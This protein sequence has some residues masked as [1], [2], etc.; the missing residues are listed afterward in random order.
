[1]FSRTVRA[2]APVMVIMTRVIRSSTWTPAHRTVAV[3]SHTAKSKDQLEQQEK[4]QN[5]KEE[6]E[7]TGTETS[8]GTISHWTGISRVRHGCAWMVGGHIP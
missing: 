3:E 8:T 7:S 1:M 4:P 5:A 2:V 6:V